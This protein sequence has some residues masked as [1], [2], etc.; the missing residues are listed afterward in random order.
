MS[1]AAVLMLAAG[2]ALPAVASADEGESEVCVL[3]SI[4]TLTAPKKPNIYETILDC[5]NE[6]TEAQ[7][8]AAKLVNNAMNEPDALEV[9]V[10]LGYE[11]E[12]GTTWISYTGREILGRYV[13]VLEGE[14]AIEVEIEETEAPAAAPVTDELPEA[15]TSEEDAAAADAIDEMDE[16]TEDEAGEDM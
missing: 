8:R 11:V 5:G 4:E 7:S 2:L 9:M 6:P 1:R 14:E 10:G 13:L 16:D 3:T 12:T 15:D